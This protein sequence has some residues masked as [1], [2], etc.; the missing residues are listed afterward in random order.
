MSGESTLKLLQGFGNQI[1]ILRKRK[2]MTGSHL[3]RSLSM[4]RTYIS[5]L[6]NGSIQPNSKMINRL[7]EYFGLSKEDRNDL[8][9]L[10]GLSSE[11][12]LPKEVSRQDFT[13]INGK[14]VERM[15]NKSEMS[16]DGNNAGIQINIPNNLQ[17]FYTDSVFV[18]VNAFGVILDFAQTMPG[19]KQQSVVARL[20]MSKDHAKAFLSVL[21]QQLD[22]DKNMV[23][24]KI[25]FS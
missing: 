13:N 16:K 9:T 7:A 5:K 10:A 19:V 23:M 25:A 24:K 15:D 8:F 1:R 21:G 6:E 12:N 11:G 17:V 2:N 3:A 4:D 20:G 22:T 14:E 18:T